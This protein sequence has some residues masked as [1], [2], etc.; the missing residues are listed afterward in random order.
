MGCLLVN[1]KQSSLKGKASHQ[2][3]DETT[4]LST[5]IVRQIINKGN[6]YTYMK[7]KIMQYNICNVCN[8]LGFKATSKAARQLLLPGLKN[9]IVVHNKHFFDT[10][11]F[12][13]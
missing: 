10:K 1:D 11:L 8:S 9:K 12:K 2:I 5:Q 13:D 7:L 6:E 4:L 3:S